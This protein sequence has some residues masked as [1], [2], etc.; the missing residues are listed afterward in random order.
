MKDCAEAIAERYGDQFIAGLFILPTEPGV[1]AD[2]LLEQLEPVLEAEARESERRWRSYASGLR[3][4]D[5]TGAVMI[6][7]GGANKA[8]A[9]AQI[10]ERI[11][12]GADGR[13]WMAFGDGWND[14]DML[15]WAEWSICPANTKDFRARRAA[16][17][18]SSLKNDEA[19]VADAIERA[20]GGVVKGGARL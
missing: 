3:Q 1:T 17:E 11:G 14:L 20:L 2:A 6:R 5:G 9:L 19:F 12:L 13:G 16:K 7:P 15:R 10:G 18:V 8:V 4:E